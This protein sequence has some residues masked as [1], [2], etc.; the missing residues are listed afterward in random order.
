MIVGYRY[1]YY[2]LF[3]LKSIIKLLDV[4]IFN[5]VGGY[6][7]YCLVLEKFYYIFE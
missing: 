4:I 7:G 1:D 2:F 3:R 6:V 5:V